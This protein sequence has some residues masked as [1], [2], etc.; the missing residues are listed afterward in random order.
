MSK[1]S[2]KGLVK[3]RHFQE[4]QK[5]RDISDKEIVKAL[6]Y[7]TLMENE[8]G[9][10]FIL[11]NLKITVDMKAGTLITAHP[12][13]PA[14]KP[15]KVLSKEDARRIFAL[16]QARSKEEALEENDFLAYV[17]ENAIKKI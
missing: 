4:R 12:K 11:G 16:I 9:A 17:K 6:T 7:G 5:Q 1:K 15:T 10:S 13:S 8:H 14:A 2:I 3:T